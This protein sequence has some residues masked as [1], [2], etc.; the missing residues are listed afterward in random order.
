MSFSSSNN[1][2]PLQPKDNQV[3]S[4][5]WLLQNR[6]LVECFPSSWPSQQA[7]EML[8]TS[9]MA[10]WQMRRLRLWEATGHAQVSHL[11]TRFLKMG[12]VNSLPLGSLLSSFFFFKD[13]CIC[14]SFWLYWSSL[15]L[16]GFS[17]VAT[18]GGCASSWCKGFSLWCLFCWAQALGHMR[19]VVETPRPRA[20]AQ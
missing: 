1:D 7:Y 19:S 13:L 12:T 20:Q 15:L 11:N 3:I 9:I 17:L 6:P 18:S 16:M 2:S 5:R 8:V 10:I 14:F 4:F